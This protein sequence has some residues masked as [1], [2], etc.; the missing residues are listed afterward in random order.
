MAEEDLPEFAEKRELLYSDDVP[1]ERVKEVGRQFMAEELF[2]D[3]LEFF[4][5]ARSVEDVRTVADTAR[6]IGDTAVW[7]RCKRILGEEPDRETLLTIAAAAEELKK[8]SFAI[9][10]WRRL[11]DEEQVER[12]RALFEAV[13]AGLD[14]GGD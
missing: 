2:N 12:L 10:A 13:T 6:D 4:E 9:E 7:L 5:R 8:Y 1:M 3:A 14:Q 11:G